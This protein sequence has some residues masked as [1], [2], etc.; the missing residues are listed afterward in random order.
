MPAGFERLNHEVYI[1]F[2]L[3]CPKNRKSEKRE[4]VVGDVTRLDRLQPTHQLIYC[5]DEGA[6]FFLQSISFRTSFTLHKPAKGF[7]N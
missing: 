2:H 3:I 1:L 7:A 5:N 4:E 6:S